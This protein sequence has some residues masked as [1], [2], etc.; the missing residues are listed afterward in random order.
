VMNPNTIE[1]KRTDERRSME[2]PFS[3]SEMMNLGTGRLPRG[4]ARPM[5]PDLP[6]FWPHSY[7]FPLTKADTA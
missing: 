6:A 2:G 4:S 5:S 3:E 1:E 7:Q